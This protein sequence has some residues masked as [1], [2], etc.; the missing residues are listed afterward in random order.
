MNEAAWRE[1]MKSNG[2]TVKLHSYFNGTVPEPPWFPPCR[3]ALYEVAVSDKLT[4]FVVWKNDEHVYTDVY[5]D[6]AYDW[7]ESEVENL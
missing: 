3:V 4:L 2:V 5:F 6:S 1:D 7:Y